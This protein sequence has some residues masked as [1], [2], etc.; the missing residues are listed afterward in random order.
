MPIESVTSNTDDLTLTAIGVYPVPVERLWA[1]WADPRQLERFWGPPQ[2]PATFTRHDMR[3]G[4]RSEYFMSGPNG[5][6]SHGYWIFE[7]V[8][9]PRAFAV[10]DGFADPDGT[11]SDAMPGTQ[12]RLTFEATPTG[13]RFVA[14]SRFPS[15]EA[16]EKL[17]AMGMKEGL[18]LAL[19]QMDDVLADLR[20]SAAGTDVELLDDTHVLITREIRGSLQ[21]VWRA[22][23]EA[24]LVQQWMLGPDG[25]TMPVCETAGEVGATYRYEWQSEADGSSFGFVGEML[26]M[27]APRR[28]VFTENMIGQEGPGTTNEM[29]LV[30]RPGG[31]TRIELRITYPSRELRDMILGTGMADGM[32]VSYARLEEV[33]G[34]EPAPVG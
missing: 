12:M 29:T 32:E 22:H 14:V 25:W 8:D 2:W 30:P 26:E 33:I 4:G 27:E 17:V 21:Q 28:V 10:R 7:E 15:L 13:S 23:Q 16:M 1:A 3:E 5:E 18:S 20:A 6:C 31:R 9:P 34:R 11:P 24:E 19:A